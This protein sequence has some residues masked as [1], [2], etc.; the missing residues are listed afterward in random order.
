MRE[1]VEYIA[2]SLVEEPDGVRVEVVDGA[3]RAQLNLYVADGDMGRI[4]GKRG[5][6]ASAI[7][8][9]SGRCASSAMSTPASSAARTPAAPPLR[10]AAKSSWSTKATRLLCALACNS[11]TSS[12]CA[13]SNP[14]SLVFTPPDVLK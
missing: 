2:K 14:K 13:P 6:M 4:I 3:Q 8:N 5:R 11:H 9:W 7:A 1:L 10:A 12:P